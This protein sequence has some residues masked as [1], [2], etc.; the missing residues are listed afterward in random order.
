MEV[1]KTEKAEEPEEDLDEGVV[2][3]P[4]PDAPESDVVDR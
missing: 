4:D 3:N 1:D 2:V